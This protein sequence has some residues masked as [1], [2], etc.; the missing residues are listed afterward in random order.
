MTGTAWVPDRRTRGRT[1]DA[2]RCFNELG[3][4][5]DAACLGDV[6][7]Y[8]QRV[9]PIGTVLPL[10]AGV[11]SVARRR[12]DAVT[13]IDIPSCD[14]QVERNIAALAGHHLGEQVSLR[15]SGGRV[16]GVSD[17]S[18]VGTPNVA[19]AEPQQTSERTGGAERAAPLAGGSG[20]PSAR[21]RAAGG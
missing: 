12:R 14:C 20:I 13:S 15:V 19:Q 8:E 4:Q 21:R 1:T 10:W 5:Q 11:R 7:G 18:W 9:S 3:R 17:L 6:H 2:R 16:P